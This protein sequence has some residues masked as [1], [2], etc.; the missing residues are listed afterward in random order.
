MWKQLL[1]LAKKLAFLAQDTQKNKA[2]IKTLQNQIEE[3]TE[4]V[5]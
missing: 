3:L 5:R 1:D 4:T 2:D